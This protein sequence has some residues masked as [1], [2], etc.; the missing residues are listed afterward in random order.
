MSKGNTK[1]AI[2]ECVSFLEYSLNVFFIFYPQFDDKNYYTLFNLA[3]CLFDLEQFREAL[4]YYQSIEEGKKKNNC[5]ILFNIG[6]CYEKLH[7]KQV[8]AISYEKVKS[9]HKILRPLK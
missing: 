8:A 1:E 5:R 2:N 3:S 4:S 9:I 6:V 7:N